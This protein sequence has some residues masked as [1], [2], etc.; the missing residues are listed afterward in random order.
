ML[1]IQIY[2]I[3]FEFCMMYL[4]TRILCKEVLISVVALEQSWQTLL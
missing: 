3:S 1:Y 2:I 4:I